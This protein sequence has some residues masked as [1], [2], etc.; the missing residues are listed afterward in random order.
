MTQLGEPGLELFHDL[1]DTRPRQVEHIGQK[2][3]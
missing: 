3:L 2:A 1:T